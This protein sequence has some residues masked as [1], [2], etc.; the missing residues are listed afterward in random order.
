MLT[1]QSVLEDVAA[2]VPA[3]RPSL[4][5]LLQRV[6]PAA[7]VGALLLV[8]LASQGGYFPT[9]WGWSGLL[10]LV[11]IAVSVVISPLP[12][13]SAFQMV[14]LLGLAGLV[15]WT[16]ASAF[17]SG[18]AG[19]SVTEAE[20]ALL[21]FVAAAAI[22][23]V[24]RRSDS[25]MLVGA[26][27]IA[28]VLI[29]SYALATRLFPGH[30]GI[31]DTTAGYRLAEPIGYW[32]TLGLLASLGILLTLGYVAAAERAFVQCV[33]SASA[34]VLALTLY[35]TFSRAAWLALGAGFVVMI[36]SAERR[37][38]VLVCAIFAAVAPALAL[39]YALRLHALNAYAQATGL[40]AAE[41]QG[42]DLFLATIG[43]AALGALLA[44]AR[45]RFEA[46]MSLPRR[47]KAGV[48]AF[49]I[50]G[51]MAGA[52]LAVLKEGGS[53]SALVDRAYNSL[54]QPT[55]RESTN[56]NQRLLSLSSNGR[57][58]LWRVAWSDFQA[59]PL[60][61]SG[62]GTFQ[63]YWLSDR[64]SSFYVRNAH[65]LYIETLAELGPVGLVLVLVALLVPLVAFFRGRRSTLTAAV[66]GAYVAFLLHAGVDWDWQLPAVTLVA[67]I[68]AA[69]MLI[70]RGGS[71]RVSPLSGALRGL[72][73]VVACVLSVVVG[74]A[75]LGN[76]ASAKAENDL[77][78]GRF[79][80][81]V[82]MAKR[83]EKL[84]PWSAQAAR[85]VGEAELGAGDPAAARAAIRHAL[86]LDD[87]SWE[88]WLDLALASTGAQ[89]AH[90]ISTARRLYP[91]SPAIAAA[92]SST[93]SSAT[94]IRRRS[95]IH[96]HVA[97]RPGS[98]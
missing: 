27:T 26:A 92:A 2:D 39:V 65:G 21:Y 57:I 52:T 93:V 59:H 82:P 3:E 16:S 94:S 35:Y 95:R 29:C 78:L 13:P 44:L 36:C 66:G 96:Q 24:I 42:R 10:L 6:A 5:A 84:Q 46:K 74:L 11:L 20:R 41:R 18:D 56:L 87:R 85:Q 43:L 31:I 79:A 60:L 68:C 8:L 80:A 12:R 62:A 14:W 58:D 1:S 86:Q 47:V 91:G 83:G 28:V 50:A 73:V 7:F 64:H 4:S 77:E 48:V 89:R 23:L 34:V 49:L 37:L 71:A 17:W 19:A 67:V 51:C 72:V 40:S 9:S 63:R 97:T 33:A 81:A 15:V 45:R 90:A 38:R 88:G 55:P 61:G 75:Y 22:V 53:P 54:K 76:V 69:A 98:K 30:F 25:T 32:N 70:Q